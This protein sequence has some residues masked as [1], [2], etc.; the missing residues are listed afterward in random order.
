MKNIKLTEKRKIALYYI[1][2][3]LSLPVITAI[4][5][6]FAKTIIN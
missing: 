6:L 1:G 2:L 3:F 4:T 5:L